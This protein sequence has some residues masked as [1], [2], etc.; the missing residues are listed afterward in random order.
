MKGM[1]TC[2]VCG[3]EFPLMAEEHYVAQDPQR[4]GVLA[5]LT[6]T[7]KA[8]EYDAFNCPHCGCQNIVQTRKPL[9]LPEMCECEEEYEEETVEDPPDHNDWQNHD[10]CFGCIY[11]D[12]PVDDEPCCNCD[13]ETDFYKKKED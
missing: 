11:N 8:I 6:N 1:T 10:S 13:T 5:N 4:V 9:W 12:V 7:D 2:K 3:R